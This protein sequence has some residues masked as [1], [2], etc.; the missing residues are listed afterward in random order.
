M[1]KGRAYCKRIPDTY[2]GRTFYYSFHP[3]ISPFGSID[4]RFRSFYST[5]HKTKLFGVFDWTEQ[6]GQKGKTGT[7]T[8]PAVLS[9]CGPNLI[10]GV[11]D[12][13]NRDLSKTK[14][15]YKRTRNARPLEVPPFDSA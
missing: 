7:I 4:T 3:Q 9:A 11:W 13:L 2:A 14:F 10:W 5:P 12:P 1:C 6:L 8:I 15:D